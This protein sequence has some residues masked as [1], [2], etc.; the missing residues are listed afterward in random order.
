MTNAC[1]A[2]GQCNYPLHEAV[3]VGDGGVLLAYDGTNWFARRN[4]HRD[5]LNAVWIQNR[6]R[7]YTVGA[8]GTI[9]R[10]SLANQDDPVRVP[11][12]TAAMLRGVHGGL[13]YLVVV[14]DNSTILFA[15]V[16]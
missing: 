7:V 13:T 1:A 2:N 5:H 15:R 11:S 6:D 12:G 10:F 16:E 14:G 3:A 8:N 4:R 9:L